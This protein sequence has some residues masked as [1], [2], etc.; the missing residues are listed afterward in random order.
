VAGVVPRSAPTTVE[1]DEAGAAEVVRAVP[2][3]PGAEHELRPVTLEVDGGLRVRGQSGGAAPREL[4]TR[5]RVTGPAARVVLDRRVLVRALALGC[6]TLK[7]S[8]NKPV[9]FAGA[10]L[11]LVAAPLD[12]ELAAAPAPGPDHRSGHEPPR[13]PVRTERPDRFPEPLPVPERSDPMRPQ[14]STN[15]RGPA[16]V[17]APEPAG[18]E[19]SDPLA[20]A[21]E[22]RAALADAA[23]KAAR[24]VTALRAGR[25]EKRALAS[26]YAGLR[27]LNLAPRT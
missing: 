17:P 18:A 12:P 5:V 26:V 21:E 23:A 14:N 9:V 10:D 20:A 27:Q 11:T 15:G 16:P 3:L 6:R 7:L 19:P 24:L 4:V 13:G 25:K 8:A 22:L 2:G 1:F